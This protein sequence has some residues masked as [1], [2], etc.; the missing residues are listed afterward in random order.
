ML[1]CETIQ[2]FKDRKMK[3]AYIVKAF[4][5]LTDAIL[6]SNL[7]GWVVDVFEDY[8]DPYDLLEPDIKVAA[9]TVVRNIVENDYDIVLVEEP[10]F[11]GQMI[12]VTEDEDVK[13]LLRRVVMC[14][15]PDQIKLELD[16]DYAKKVCIEA[17]VKVTPYSLITIDENTDFQ[18]LKNEYRGRDKIVL[19]RNTGNM[20][21][22]DSPNTAFDLLETQ[23]KQLVQ[24]KIRCEK[25]N[26]KFEEEST[27]RQLKTIIVED[28]V[29]LRNAI[30]FSVCGLANGH[31][32]TPMCTLFDLDNK[33][34]AGGLGPKIS[35]VSQIICD[36]VS[37]RMKQFVDMLSDW[38]QST[39]YR[40]WLDIDL[41][42]LPETS[43]FMCFEFMVRFG[44]PT[45]AAII[46]LYDINWLNLFLL[47]NEEF[48]V[49]KPQAVSD[50]AVGVGL[51]SFSTE[52]NSMSG[53]I[54]VGAPI[55]GLKPYWRKRPSCSE[56]HITTIETYYD[57]DKDIMYLSGDYGR[58]M[59]SIG[60]AN[61]WQDALSNAYD[62]CRAVTYPNKV[63]K[64]N[65]FG[66]YYP[67]AADVKL[68]KLW[69]VIKN[70]I[71][72]K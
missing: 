41:F 45:M 65:L 10:F 37:P 3:K 59:Y 34:F 25:E 1:C 19:K 24:E 7:T 61:T 58:H 56:C 18:K 15:T 26:E 22:V 46:K 4:S 54:P 66:L 63:Y 72:A 39:H 62:G 57:K 23:Y 40:G 17:G 27:L 67:D 30:E 47:A 68:D 55:N 8:K 44:I 70:E 52:F 12:K 69:P 6:G 60:L 9:R 31:T 14:G 35:D 48:D 53:D 20:F 42:Y 38:V 5:G 49:R 32:F 16:R 33:I 29:D 51:F 28:Y 36:G 50:L 11:Y 64:T 43:E 2:Q 13:R 71:L 21:T